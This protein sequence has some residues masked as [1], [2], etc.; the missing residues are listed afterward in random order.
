MVDAGI[1][2]RPFPRLPGLEFRLGS[3]D[4]YDLR[5]HEP[6]NTVYCAVRILY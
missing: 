5:L 1:A 4:S 2:V 3:A 6:E